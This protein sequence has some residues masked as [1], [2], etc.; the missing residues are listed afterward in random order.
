MTAAAVSLDKVT[1]IFDK[2][3]V[4]DEL[5]FEIKEGEMYGLLGP[6]G[7]GKSTTIRMLITLTE[8]SGGTIHIAG[9]DI[10]ANP[11]HAK[12]NIGVVLQQM[13][14]DVDLTVWE[15]L[16]FHA[17]LHHIPKAPRQRLIRQSLEYVELGDRRDALVKT[18]S[19]GMKRRVQ[20]ARAL[21]HEPK[22]LFLDEPTVGLDPQTRRRLW[23]IIR[24]LNTNG[25]T[26]LLTTHYMEEATALC[27]RIGIMEAGK[28]IEEGTFTQMQAKYGKGL[29]V[30]QRGDRWEYD[31]FP[32]VK[33]AE[34][35]L[36]KLADKA[37]VMVRESNLEDIFVDLTGRQLD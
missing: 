25:M 19:G 26:I 28:L 1:K 13:S 36:D 23:E 33:D 31:F 37:G 17:R 21:L 14:V 11:A 15:N 4:V 16:E 12:R 6:N 9:E 3:P 34:H 22:I 18:L 10:Q 32:T 30:K 8:P 24:E 29:M 7:A 20:I 27:D 5:S 2:I 35:Q